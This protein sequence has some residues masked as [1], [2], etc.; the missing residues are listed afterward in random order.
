[1]TQTGT[2]RPASVADEADCVGP[3][4]RRASTVG[5]ELAG[6]PLEEKLV[7]RVGQTAKLTATMSITKAEEI[8]VTAE[9]PIVD[10]MKMDASTNI[11]PEQIQELPVP[12]REFEKLA[13]IAPGVQRE[14]G[15][16]RFITNSPVVGSGG[17]ASQTTIMVDG[18]D[19]TDQALGLS[20]V[21]FSQ[22][23]IR[24]FRVINNR[25]DSEI[26]NSQGGALSIVTR[27]GSNLVQGSAFGFYR[28][29]SLR[30]QGELETGDQDFTRYR[31]VS[32]SAARSRPTRPALRLVRVHRRGGTS[33]SSDRWAR[34][35]ARPRTSRTRSDARPL[36]LHQ[37]ALAVPE[38]PGQGGRRPLPGET[39]ASAAWPTS[40]AACSSTATT[41]TSTP[42]TPGRLARLDEQPELPDRPEEVRRAQQLGQHVRVLPFGTTLIT[43]ANIVGDQTMTGD[44]IE[45]RDTY[46]LY[47]TGE[48]S[49]HDLKLGVSAQWI[50]EWWYPVFPTG[51]LFWAGDTV[52]LPYRYDYG[53]GDPNTKIGTELYGVFVQ[54]DWRIGRNFTVSLGVRYDMTPTATTPTSPTGGTGEAPRRRRQH[55]AAPGVRVRISAATA[56]AS[57]AAA[58]ACSPAA[59]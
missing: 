53:V 22:D 31:P 30:T 2:E 6:Y 20:R 8:T 37:P 27:S 12:S 44:Y 29:D 45:L 16:F 18:V 58:P 28:G 35:P 38:P 39:S 7:L 59:T 50:D 5:F 24:E 19:Y 26:A 11:V 10:A 41:T 21:R 17:N 52:P 54:D 25:F 47:L 23:A 9:A 32:P 56:A 13:F 46:H 15:G 14:R 49:S 55:P 48:K 57:S 34:S 3:A 40:R 4:S 33:R 1:V 51:L 43:G 36:E 42:G